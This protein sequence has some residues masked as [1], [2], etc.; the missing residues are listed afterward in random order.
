MFGFITVL[1]L[2]FI[3]FKCKMTYSKLDLET[4]SSYCACGRIGYCRSLVSLFS[5]EGSRSCFVKPDTCC[6]FCP[7]WGELFSFYYYYF[8]D[9]SF[10]CSFSN[11]GSFSVDQAVIELRD[12]P[13]FA[14]QVPWLISLGRGLFIPVF[15]FSV[16]WCFLNNWPVLFNWEKNSWK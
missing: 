4:V 3:R 7:Q 1:L 15:K 8:Q 2:A 12:T 14:S 13:T 16:L 5:S 10:L 6:S 11:P 9:R